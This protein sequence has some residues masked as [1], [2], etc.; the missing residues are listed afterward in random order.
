MEKDKGWQ[1][2]NQI[3]LLS[4]E[5]LKVEYCE[6]STEVILDQPHDTNDNILMET[7]L[8]SMREST[9]C[10]QKALNFKRKYKKTINS[11]TIE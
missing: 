9:L 11:N 7:L 4:A 8:Y 3:L 1:V 6:V 2:T 5:L 10:Y